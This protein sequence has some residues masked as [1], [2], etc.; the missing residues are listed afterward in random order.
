LLSLVFFGFPHAFTSQ[1]SD[2]SLF[3]LR[4]SFLPPHRCA[5]Y[6]SEDGKWN[7]FGGRLAWDKGVICSNNPQF[8][9]AGT[10]KAEDD[11]T[12]APNIDHSQVRGRGRGER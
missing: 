2:T 8:G 4:P 1:K 3:T 10:R 7:K 5:H 12:A 11:Y 6:Q 9:G